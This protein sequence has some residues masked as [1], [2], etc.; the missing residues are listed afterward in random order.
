MNSEYETV[1]SDNE[2]VES[3]TDNDVGMVQNAE[4]EETS[5][6]MEKMRFVAD[7]LQ[8][9]VGTPS[10]KT[11]S[12][13]ATVAPPQSAATPS[14]SKKQKNNEQILPSPEK[15]KKRAATKTQKNASTS[16]K[17]EEVEPAP[18]KN[19]KKKSTAKEPETV[20][21]MQMMAQEL[22]AARDHSVKPIVFGQD[23]P[24]N[25]MFRVLSISRYQEKGGLTGIKI[26]TETKTLLPG[27]KYRDIFLKHFFCVDKQGQPLLDAEKKP[28]ESRYKDLIKDD[29]IKIKGMIMVAIDPKDGNKSN[30]DFIYGVFEDLS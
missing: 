17:P 18:K 19:S 30:P 13:T 9:F 6:D 23:F 15:S 22:N 29:A 8:K 1:D 12:K 5:E 24:K 7:F 26:E 16:A 3:A 4:T 10:Q 27:F 21:L 14:T 25:T 11:S 2:S 20:S 28:I